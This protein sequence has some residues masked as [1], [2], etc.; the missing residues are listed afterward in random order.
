MF[1]D[2]HTSPVFYDY[3]GDGYA[4]RTAWVG[5]HEGI[6][7]WDKTGNV[8]YDD[9]PNSATYGQMTGGGIS[10]GEVVLTKGVDG[11]TDLDVLLKKF[12]DNDDGL[13]DEDELKGT[14]GTNGG[15]LYVWQDKT[16]DGTPQNNEV[17]LLT[18]V[19]EKIDAR[20]VDYL[21]ADNLIDEDGDGQLDDANPAVRFRD[22]SLIYGTA[23]VKLQNGG[24]TTAYDMAFAHD[25]YGIK[26]KGDGTQAAARLSS[27]PQVR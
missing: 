14:A 21:D 27:P 9:D 17:Q 19:V 23:K 1:F 2:R 8:T 5:P 12:D 22:G 24:E 26:R 13:L 10:T 18:N 6:V 4:E 11:A 3:D 20:Q 16:L 25:E 7:V 15:R